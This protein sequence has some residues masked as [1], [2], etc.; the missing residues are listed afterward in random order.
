MKLQTRARRA[1]G[2]DQLGGGLH[3]L[4]QYAATRDREIRRGLGMNETDQMPTRA[5]P[6][7]AARE[8]YAAQH[9]PAHCRMQIVDPEAK[10]VQ[11]RS[12]RD[13][14]CIRVHGLHQVELDTPEAA[15][16]RQD[17]F[18]DVL[19]LASELSLSLRPQTIYP[20]QLECSAVQ[21]SERD[22]LH[23]QH[24]EGPGQAAISPN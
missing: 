2:G 13:G 15:P 1:I 16:E 6:H 22:L 9:E 21:A 3:Q 14:T 17:R 11:G 5:A 23:A 19:R 12:V 10:V 8:A 20:K 24:A 4:D 7:P 18:I